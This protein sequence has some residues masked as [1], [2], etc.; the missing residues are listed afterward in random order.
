MKTNIHCWSYFAHFFL[1]WEKFWHI[2]CRENQNTHFIFGH[3]F[4]LENCTVN[5]IIWKTIVQRVKPQVTIWRMCVA[6]WI[7]T[8]TNT[9]SEY[10]IAIA[11]PL[12]QCLHE[13]PSMLHWTCSACLVRNELSF[14]TIEERQWDGRQCFY[15][16][17]DDYLNVIH[18]LALCKTM[19]GMYWL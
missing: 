6:C 11:F 4:F 15:F 17:T 8:A 10:V 5:E 3:F 7:T 2:S 19:T 13:R 12:Q 1:E 16:L 14:W 9:H 18:R